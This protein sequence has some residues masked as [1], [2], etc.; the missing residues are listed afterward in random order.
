VYAGRRVVCPCCGGRFRRFLPFRARPYARCPRCGSLER[1]RL[2]ALYVRDSQSLERPHLRLLHVAPE[3]GFARLLARLPNVE[4]VSG[5][6]EPRRAMVQLDVTALPFPEESF[7][8][9]VC[10]HVLEH[11]PDDRAA[12][13][14]LYRVLRPGGWALLLSAVDPSLAVTVEEPTLA[15]PEER[16]RRFGQEDHVRIY[17]LDYADRLA[18]AGFVVTVDHYGRRLGEQAATIYGIRPEEAVYRCDRP[19]AEAPGSDR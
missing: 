2:L 12:L 19:A 3:P 7:D 13:A 18:A 8:A 4:Y 1:H 9:V 15:D 10:N 6:L 17:G 14:E 11:V 16:L 5:D